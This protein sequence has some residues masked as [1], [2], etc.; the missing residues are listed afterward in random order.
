MLE[1]G[2]VA[3]RRE[4]QVRRSRTTSRSPRRSV[5][6]ASAPGRAGR[7]VPRSAPA[8]C[9]VAASIAPCSRSM[10]ANSSAYSGLPPARARSSAWVSAGSTVVSRSSPTRRAVSSSP[11]A[12]GEI[13]S[14]FCLPPPQ[15]GRRA[16]SS[17]RA[18]HDDEERDG[19]GP[20]DEVVDE[21]EQ[22]LVGPVEVLEDEHERPLVGETLEE[23]PPGCESLVPAIAAAE[24]RAGEADQRSQVGRRS[25]GRRRPL[26]ACARPRARRRP[27]GCRPAL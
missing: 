3:V 23:P 4:T 26:R 5:R 7:A 16:R 27:R 14:E 1:L 15:P 18:V 11:S 2:A 19:R 17:G 22:A 13:V 9:R 25:T 6:A 10:R 21:V 20:V 8:P 24:V 12:T